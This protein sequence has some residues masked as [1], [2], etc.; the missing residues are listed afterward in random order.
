MGMD[1]DGKIALVTGAN[2]GIGRAIVESLLKHGAAKVYAA[3]RNTASV[4]PLAEKYGDRV[5]AVPVDMQRP[6]TIAALA[7]S[8][9]DAEIVINNA[10]VL[11]VS[12]PLGENTI[13]DFEYELQVNVFGLLHMARAFAPV[14]K[15][16]GGGAFVQLNSVASMK[17]FEGFATYSASKAAA[18]SLTLALRQQ[19][20]EQGTQVLSVHPGPI[21][22]DMADS[23]GL[24]GMGEPASV[25][26]E[27]LVAALKSGDF[28]L[29]PD[30]MAKKIGDQ[31]ASFAEAIVDADLMAG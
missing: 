2:R 16:N 28:R 12:P 19:L 4:A 29:F 14:L 25:V 11:R 18:Y 26:G 6:D 9:Q 20:G 31:Y 17:C 13:E 24:T 5:V 15:A 22:T 8:C 21:D 30:S 27:G 1:V 10:G 3:V 7:D 23:A